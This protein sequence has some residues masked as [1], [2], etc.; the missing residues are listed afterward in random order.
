[1]HPFQGSQREGTAAAHK[2]GDHPNCTPQPCHPSRPN[3]AGMQYPITAYRMLS[4]GYRPHRA[5]MA[6]LDESQYKLLLEH[7]DP[8][9]QNYFL[10]QQ[11]L[12]HKLLE[13]HL[14]DYGYMEAIDYPI[15]TG[16]FYKFGSG[17]ATFPQPCARRSGTLHHATKHGNMRETQPLGSSCGSGEEEGWELAVLCG[18]AECLYPP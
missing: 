16:M 8:P 12:L 7:L 4:L 14:E 18:L 15:H 10:T 5:A 17:T 3:L 6:L 9:F 13:K 11:R 2:H 1:M